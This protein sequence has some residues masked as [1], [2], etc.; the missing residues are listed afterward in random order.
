[1]ALGPVPH[2]LV[3]ERK[4]LAPSLLTSTKRTIVHTLQGC[5]GSNVLIRAQ[6]LAQCLARGKCSINIG[7]CRYQV[8]QSS[9]HTG[10]VPPYQWKKMRQALTA[11]Q[12]AEFTF[13][14]PEVEGHTAYTLG[15]RALLQ[16]SPCGEHQMRKRSQEVRVP[17][18]KNHSPS[19]HH[20]PCQGGAWG[21]KDTQDWLLPPGAFRGT[22]FTSV[23]TAPSLLFF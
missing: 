4:L 13:G 5:W 12:G 16:G 21:D 7:H 11:V 9:L 14:L 22:P 8:A 6:H 1:M 3:V 23:T 18:H 19:S 20:M 10:F 2:H 15:G 17:L